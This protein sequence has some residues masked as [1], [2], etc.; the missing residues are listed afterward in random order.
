LWWP[1]LQ[2]HHRFGLGPDV[3]V[4]LWWA[5]VGAA[6]GLSLVGER[7]GAP[8][9]IATLAGTLHLSDVA[10]V[11]AL[12]C[13][14][15]TATGLGVAT[16]LRRG[17]RA[18]RR[19]AVRAAMLLGGLLSGL[20]A[21]HLAA[22]YVSNLEMTV[23]F[24][25]AAA[26]LAMGE[27]RHTVGAAVLLGGSALAHPLFGATGGVILA[28]SALWAWREGER[29]EARRIGA[30]TAAAGAATLA[31]MA[32]M[33][34][35][36][37]RLMVDTS[38]DGFLRRTGLGSTLVSD[39]RSRFIHR[40]TRYVQ[41]LSI[42]L[43][44]PGTRRLE[45]FRRRFLLTWLA[46]TLVG[47]AVGFVSGWFPPD[48]MI[49]FGFAIPALAG[50]GVVAAWEWLSAR[51]VTLAWVAA[52]L[53]VGAMAAGSLMAYGRQPTFISPDE[54]A[55]VTAAGRL[56]SAAP[57]GTTL[58]FV[59]DNTDG[60]AA[61]L[62]TRAANVIRA[63]LPPGRAT[64]AYVYVGVPANLSADR[65][66]LRGD[67]Q[68]DALSRRYLADIPGTPQIRFVLAAFDASGASDHPAGFSLAAPGVYVD[69]S[70]VSGVPPSVSAAPQAV[71]PL[72]PSSPGGIVVATCA[73]LAL[74]VLVGGGWAAWAVRDPLEVWLLAPGFGL[75]TLI[76]V[77]VF[78]ERLGLPLN[79][80]VGPTVVSA[81]S[82][83]SGY[84]L[85]FLGR[86]SKARAVS[87]PASP[88]QE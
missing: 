2:H 46:V 6:G 33:L 69:S 24:L 85:A 16:L 14:L 28:G 13:G 56:A 60:T 71:D 80:W 3:P 22:G 31:G 23:P 43:A 39:Y 25:A 32:S 15:A 73:V 82:G 66:T 67:P 38:K 54:V 34:I 4:Y 59:V 18:D 62:A 63:A 55:Q 65:P 86:G 8:A 47:M 87:D 30:A 26:L 20:F 48:R 57:T 17:I 72:L 79:G 81:A 70:E 12:E 10:V 83:G 61:F 35:G 74:L 21:V 1:F 50:V 29:A 44:A 78:M 51:A 7:P 19:G 53:A 52:V 41:W 45:G 76:L 68:Y 42:P 88:V 58:V 77:G 84:V 64:D 5:R 49:T 36:P 37:A 40:W 11:A 75:A 9:L 27:R